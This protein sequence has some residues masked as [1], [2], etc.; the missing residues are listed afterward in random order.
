[1]NVASINVKKIDLKFYG[2]K[3]ANCTVVVGLDGEE[4]STKTLPGLDPEFEENFFFKVSDPATQK[5]WAKVI[6]DGQ[7]I[8]DKQTYPL[9][10]LVKNKDTFKGVIVPGGKAD[11]LVKAIDF[12]EEQEAETDDSFAD[13]L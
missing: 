6:M 3:K 11:M 2:I 7:Q 12:G 4:M 5:L 10:K 13:F 9:N 8:G 1:M